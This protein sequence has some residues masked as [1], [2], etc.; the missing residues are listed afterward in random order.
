LKKEL[1]KEVCDNTEIIFKN[2]EILKQEPNM[3]EKMKE[4]MKRIIKLDSF[5]QRSSIQLLH[6][7]DTINQNDLSE[8]EIENILKKKSSKYLLNH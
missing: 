5:L 1:K 3:V 6:Q 4:M 8:I 2:E 7:I